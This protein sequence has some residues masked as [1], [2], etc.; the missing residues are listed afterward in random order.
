MSRKDQIRNQQKLGNSEMNSISSL[1]Y[2]TSSMG[3]CYRF[4]EFNN[5]RLSTRRKI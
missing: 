5:K 2:E 4:K 1:S 3:K